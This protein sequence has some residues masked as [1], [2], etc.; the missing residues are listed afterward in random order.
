MVYR[1]L[2]ST[3]LSK[4]AYWLSAALIVLSAFFVY[5]KW[6][7]TETEATIGWDVSGYYMYLPAAFIYK[8]LREARFLDSMVAKY[9][10]TPAP[11]QGFR[12][13]SGRFVMKYS[14]GQALQ[15]LPFFIV[16]HTLAKPLGFPADGFSLPYQ[17][18]IAWGSLLIALLGLWI[19]RRNLLA[20]FSERTVAITLVCLAFA[21]NY[22]NYTAFD[23]AMTHNW[24][25]TCYSLLIFCTIQFY[26]KPSLKWAAGIGLFYGWAVLTRPTEI[27]GVL[28]PL[29]WGLDSEAAL[30]GRLGFLKTHFAKVLLAAGVCLAVGSIQLLYWKFSADQW[31]VYS[32]EEQG[33]SW[34]KPHL[35]D[36]LFSYRAGWL[37]WSPVMFLAVSGFF[38]L[39]QQR[40]AIFPALL[41]FCAVFLYVTSAWDIWW[42]G[43]SLGSRAMVQSYA[44]WIFPLAA[45]I[46]WVTAFSWSRWVLPVFIGGCTWM[47]LWWSHEAHCGSG[48]FVSEQM[49]KKF[50]W[51]GI[52]QSQLDRDWLKLLDTR[53]EFRGKERRNVREVFRQD[54]EKDTAH[55]VLEGPISGAKSWLLDR[56]TQY[57]PEYDLPIKPGDGAWVRATVTFKSDP[58]EWEAWRMTQ[59]IV[60][61]YDGDKKVRERMI[62]LHRHVDGN[63]VK[64]V[65]FDTK[66]PKMP[67]TRAT[68]FFWH[69]DG[70]KALRLDDLKV[71]VFE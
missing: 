48:L 64:T 54:F 19:A 55:V 2:R 14:S 71:E 21:S 40:P 9:H 8:D 57:T 61:F 5:P 4:V 27:V 46:Q 28:I 35:A 56:A 50:F 38:A 53:D 25:F 10:P 22:L 23:G 52:G 37:T 44:A 66:F 20:Y 60:R 63:E 33:F 18:A 41:A 3:T 6:E 67:F 29:L 36:V 68:V 39:E 47:N 43:G 12:L 1:A 65:F 51:R 70:D 7:K 13:P 26:K 17:A 49:T 30:R 42:Y 15:F 58:K 34:L 31:L 45:F 62:R 69:A 59:F 32:Y 24:L 11:M 16:A